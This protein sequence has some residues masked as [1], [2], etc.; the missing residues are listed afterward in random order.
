MVAKDIEKRILWY[1]GTES[2]KK[3]DIL[4]IGQITSNKIE[5]IASSLN[6]YSLISFLTQ[7]TDDFKRL[8]VKNNIINSKDKIF[9]LDCQSCGVVLP[10]FP[11]KSEYIECNN[12]NYSQ[13]IW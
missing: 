11:H 2:V 5:I 6:H 3:E 4:A 12:C 10:Y 7:I 1:F 8:V 9:D 13:L